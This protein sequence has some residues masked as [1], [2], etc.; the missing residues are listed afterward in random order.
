MTDTLEL[1]WDIVAVECTNWTCDSPV[2]V[3][4]TLQSVHWKWNMMMPHALSH[5]QHRNCMR[6]LAGIWFSAVMSTREHWLLNYAI[7]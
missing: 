3:Q 4:Q 5:M 7:H 6:H 2:R 1:E